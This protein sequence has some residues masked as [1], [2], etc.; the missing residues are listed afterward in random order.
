MPSN[1]PATGVANSSASN[2]HFHADPQKIHASGG[3][4]H[5]LISQYLDDKKFFKPRDLQKL[6]HELRTPVNHII[7]YGELLAD[8]AQEQG[9]AE[10]IADL[11]KIQKAARNW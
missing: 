11:E 2:T 3:E 1:K 10:R 6:Y 7:G 8:L 5:S 9:N 4:L